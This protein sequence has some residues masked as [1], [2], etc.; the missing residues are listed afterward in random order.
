MRLTCKTWRCMNCSQIKISEMSQTVAD[1]TFD[2]SFIHEVEIRDKD[3]DKVTRYFRTHD[4]SSLSVKMTD[5]IF[6]LSSGPAVGKGW[7]TREIARAEAIVRIHQLNPKYIKRRDFTLD[8][9]PEARYDPKRDTVVL[10]TT[11]S[12][13]DDL[14]FTLEEFGQTID[15]EYV[16]GD[17]LDVM[18][19][20][21]KLR[22]DLELNF[23]VT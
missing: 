15:S 18:E 23:M 22:G 5:G 1:A 14:K 13:M 8:W 20:F 10:A 19:R 17:P 2:V 3:R 12:S 9:R 6:V 16:E 21:A 11:F 4:I 7:G